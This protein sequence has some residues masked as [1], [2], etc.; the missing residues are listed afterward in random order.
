MVFSYQADNA[1]DFSFFKLGLFYIMM[2][3]SLLKFQR[4]T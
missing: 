1:F 4:R 3:W 2:V